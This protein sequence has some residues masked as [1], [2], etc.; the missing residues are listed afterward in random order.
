MRLDASQSS[1]FA[2]ALLLTLPTLEGVSTLELEGTVVSEPYIEATLAVL[3]HHR[4]EV[5][6]VGRRFSIPGGQTYRGRGMRVPGDASSAAYLWGAAAV[7]GGTVRVKG[8][9]EEWPQA[10]LAILDLLERAGARVRRTRDGADVA[11]PVTQG[12]RADLTGAPD[13][14][15][16]A[17]VLAA[18]VPRRGELRGAPQVVQKES[19]RRAGAARLARSMGADV[20]LRRGSLEIRGAR[21]PRALRL[22]DL[23]DHRMIMSA[24]VAARVGGGRSTL[25]DARAVA[26]SFPEFWSTLDRLS[27]AAR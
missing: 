3:R 16:L 2:S 11:G 10:D 4:I 22:T 20:R 26:K 6:R 18:A 9:P 21:A 12:F 24:A 25:G 19:D 27:E 17:A 13:L 7:T 14:Y 23:D 15:P 8:I 1:Q 5:R